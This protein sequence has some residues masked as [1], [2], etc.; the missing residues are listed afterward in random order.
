MVGGEQDWLEELGSGC[1]EAGVVGGVE[2]GAPGW[3]G[4][5]AGLLSLPAHQSIPGDTA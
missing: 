3:G 4:R 1:R 2:E 5:L